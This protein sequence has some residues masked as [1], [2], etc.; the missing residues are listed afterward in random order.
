MTP[1]R[2]ATPL[3]PYARLSRAHRDLSVLHSTVD[4]FGRA[5]WLL[6]GDPTAGRRAKPYDAVVVT[7]EDG[8]PHETRLGP[9]RAR[10]P[11]LDALPDG[12]FVVADARSRPGDEQV[13]V[14]DALGRPSWTFRVGDAVEHLLT[15]ESGDLW[16]GHFDEGVYGDDELARPGLRRWSRT[17]EP[18]WSYHPVHGGGEISD[19]YALNVGARSAW[20]CAY[21]DFAL[22]EIAAGREARA[23]ANQVSG[24]QGLAVHAG[25]AAFV[26]GYGDAHDRLVVGRLTHE[27]FVAVEER[28][29]VRPDGSPLGR[30]RIVSR[31]PRVYVQEEPFTEWTVFDLDAF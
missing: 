25:R 4:A 15:D 5:H 7:V 27:D 11:L 9:L 10:F 1:D 8:L 31:G 29:L 20:A 18:L 19:C 6:S 13:Q 14:L 12:G 16:V 26:G 3:A 30:R 24:A 21:T 22:L 17:G 2:P 23:R 28:R